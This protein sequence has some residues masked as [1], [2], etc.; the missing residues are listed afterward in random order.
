M[1][2][3][4]KTHQAA[5]YETPEL[6]KLTKISHEER[7]ENLFILLINGT[8]KIASILPTDMLDLL[9]NEELSPVIFDH[10]PEVK[11]H[12]SVVVN[13]L[14]IVVWEV[15]KEVKWFIGYVKEIFEDGYTV[16]PLDQSPSTL[17]DFWNYPS[18]DDIQTASEEQIIPCKIDGDWEPTIAHKDAPA[19]HPLTQ[20]A[21]LFKIFF[22][23]SVFSVP[24]PFKVFR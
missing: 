1:S 4:R 21:P 2:Y 17:N 13:Q 24:P 7:L 12:A 14:C 5:R 11:N 3:Y 18:P 22:S 10:T 23:P 20:L 8:N 6:F 9:F 15:E 16:E 19:P